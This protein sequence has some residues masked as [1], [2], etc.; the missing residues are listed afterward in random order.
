MPITY[1]IT[2]Y[3]KLKEITKLLLVLLRAAAPVKTAKVISLAAWIKEE[4]RSTTAFRDEMLH[5]KRLIE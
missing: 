3:F 2:V 4:Q 1:Y 5:S